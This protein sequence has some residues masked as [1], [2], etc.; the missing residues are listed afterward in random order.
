M[1]L[2]CGEGFSML[3]ND[4]DALYNTFLVFDNCIFNNKIEN[5]VLALLDDNLNILVKLVEYV[6]DMST[7]DYITSE[8]VPWPK[9]SP[10]SIVEWLGFVN[11]H[12]LMKDKKYHHFIHLLIN[13]AVK[14]AK[15]ESYEM[16]VI[17]SYLYPI[18][19][20]NKFIEDKRTED[21]ILELH[22][23]NIGFY[24]TE[25]LGYVSKKL[26]NT[27]INW[28]NKF[29]E[30]ADKFNSVEALYKLKVS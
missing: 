8:S 30:Y 6:L 26:L 28:N 27:V 13:V 24:Y 18:L 14:L 7:E 5:N 3:F 4:G 10:M 11:K 23:I 22:K 17:F 25:R 21:I 16:K 20:E 15:I 12:K 2:T 9:I 29:P 19:K 1:K